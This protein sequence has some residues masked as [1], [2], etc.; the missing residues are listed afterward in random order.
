MPLRLRLVELVAA[1]F[2]MTLDVSTE[3]L[4][5]VEVHKEIARER[6]NAFFL[7]RPIANEAS[8]YGE[9]FQ[10]LYVL[11]RGLFVGLLLGCCY[12]VGWLLYFLRSADVK[13]DF[14]VILG[15]SF[16]AS[17][18][19]A[20]WRAFDTHNLYE[21]IDYAALLVLG[22]LLMMGG[23]IVAEVAKPKPTSIYLLLAIA[24]ALPI[25]AFRFYALYRYF[26]NEFAKAIWTYFAVSEPASAKAGSQ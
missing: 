21:T 9:Q 10:G 17:L 4:L 5:D 24:G 6:N 25:A 7:C 26:A 2:K 20:L 14:Q 18:A 13:Y 12:H 8:N 16:V 15:I 23:E 19:L 11:M 22:L 3:V 1:R